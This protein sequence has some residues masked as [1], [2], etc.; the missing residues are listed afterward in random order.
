MKLNE[1]LIPK[2]KEIDEMKNLLE[3]NLATGGDPAKT[4]RKVDGKD[5]YIQKINIGSGPNNGSTSYN[6]KT[7]D[8]IITN[9]YVLG[10][11]SNNE[12]IYAP[13]SSASGQ[14]FNVFFTGNQVQLASN[15][16]RSRFTCYLYI[17]YIN[18]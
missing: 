13:N 12:I 14:Y 15:I 16:D 6:Y 17:S 2:L 5:E 7:D 3:Y 8:K 10:I 11:S 9:Y 18:K 4:G 1:K